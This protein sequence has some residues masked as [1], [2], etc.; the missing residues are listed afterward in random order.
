MAPVTSGV[1]Q[2]SVLGS[3][4]FLM[5]INDLPSCAKH[6]TTRLFADDCV[7]YRRI[8]SCQDNT[9]LRKDLDALLTWEHKWLMEFNPSKCQVIR[10]TNKRQ[11]IPTTYTIHGHKLEVVESAKYLGVH[12]DS[13]INFNTHIDAV[14]F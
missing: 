8:T 11:P 5:Y 13:N 12:L 10:I 14:I 3:L 6:S 2:G 9:T 7:L 1:P 4:L